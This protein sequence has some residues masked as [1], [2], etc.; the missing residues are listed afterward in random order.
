MERKKEN[1]HIVGV[2]SATVAQQIGMT[3]KT[4]VWI[5]DKIV[6]HINNRHGREFS[7]MKT[8]VF[9]FVHRVISSFTDAYQQKDG[10]VLLAIKGGQ[11]SM[12]TYIK[13]EH[14]EENYWRVKSAHIRDN[15]ELVRYKP[16]WT[17]N[18][19]AKKPA[20]K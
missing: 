6:A 11:K 5:S 17:K 18:S 1:W 3:D 2:I 9:A 13:L 8:T 7:N 20:K 15:E 16:I 14:A 4:P 10:T 12:C 19:Q